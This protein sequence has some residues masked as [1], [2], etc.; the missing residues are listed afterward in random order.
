[1]ILE[2][3]HTSFFIV[4]IETTSDCNF[5][6]DFCINRKK[7]ASCATNSSNLV[8]FA[9]ITQFLDYLL[10]AN[11]QIRVLLNGGEPTLHP[12]LLE[13]L[14]WCKSKK[15]DV[16]ILTNLSAK[17]EAYEAIQN[18]STLITPTY[19]TNQINASEF[20]QK[21][22]ALKL[23]T[24]LLPVHSEQELYTIKNAFPQYVVKPQ[25]IEN[26]NYSSCEIDQLSNKDAYFKKQ[27][28]IFRRNAQMVGK[29]HICCSLMSYIYINN[30]GSICRCMFNESTRLGTT[31]C[32]QGWSKM[33]EHPSYVCK[34][35]YCH[36]SFK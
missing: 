21:M 34:P 9:A 28:T 8:D 22:D 18:A 33:L 3:S 12:R 26:F 16:E 20:A 4:E 5:L 10:S 14:I 36:Y 24:M 13:F 7:Q 27:A 25:L 31:T 30:D 6:C 1:M 19:H 15:I 2:F 32:P 23:K 35:S 11:K 29:S 17:I